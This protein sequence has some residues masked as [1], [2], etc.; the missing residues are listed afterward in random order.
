MTETAI[1]G[2]VLEAYGFET[3]QVSPLSGGLIN[4]TFLVEH[5]TARVVLQCLHP[6]FG[7][8][9][10]LDLDA[11]TSHLAALDLPTPRLLRSA[12]GDACVVHEDRVWRVL[13]H[14]AGST[15]HRI[16]A[17]ACAHAAGHMVGR[18]HR[19]VS[20]LDYQY[21]FTRSGVH[22]TAAHLSRL[23]RVAAEPERV[24][25][26]PDSDREWLARARE[27]ARD[28]LDAAQELPVLDA[29]PL[30]HTHGDLKISNI[31]FA[32]GDP[33]RAIALLDLDTL[34]RQ[35]LAYEL[36]DAL[37]SWCNPSGE[38]QGR[39]RIDHEI[40]AAAMDGYRA[41]VGDL[42]SAEEW[43]AIIPGL[44]TICVELAARFCVDV[45][46]DQY[47]GWDETRF[48][49]RREHNLVRAGGQLFLSRSVRAERAQLAALVHG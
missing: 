30:R 39:A 43:A 31:L 11:V 18:F 17:P 36:G 37:R 42:A 48:S 14:L 3:A 41:S 15:I 6:I 19:A 29:L 4:R 10:N 35:N 8:E 9:V 1:P 25:T 21:A 44:E 34:G 26:V 7:P 16:A 46:E 24:L 28:I 45:F 32:E 2:R 38:D 5:G 27:L 13:S 49:S 33:T 20:D 47:F 40:L 22:D 12:K 23:E